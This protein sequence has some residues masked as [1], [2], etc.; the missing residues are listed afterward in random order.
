MI[1]FYNR[2]TKKG[3]KRRTS[4]YSLIELFILKNNR[5]DY[6]IAYLHRMKRSGSCLAGQKLEPWL[7]QLVICLLLAA[8]C[9]VTPA[10]SQTYFDEEEEEEEEEVRDEYELMNGGYLRY[11]A[12]DR[13]EQEQ[14]YVGGLSTR[15]LEEEVERGDEWDSDVQGPPTTPDDP[16][17]PVNGY[18]TVLFVAGLAFGLY[19]LRSPKVSG[20]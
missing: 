16:D 13:R 3:L 6:I 9:L 7:R 2:T 11:R 18:V 12:H 20:N 5:L 10:W 15:S 14:N 8:G 19:R 1:C 17:A 4:S